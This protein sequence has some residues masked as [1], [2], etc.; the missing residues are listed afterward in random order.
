MKRIYFI[1][2]IIISII[3]LVPVSAD[4]IN[5][6]SNNAILYNI[7]DDIVLYEKNKDQKVSIASMTKLMTALVAVENIDNLNTKVK[8]E[9]S[10]YEKL[11]IQ[12]AS[13]SSL[14]R[15]RYYT[16]EDLLYGLILES[17]ADCANAL[18]RLTAGNEENFVKK[19]NE[20]AKI[21]GMNN[22]KFSNPIGLDNVNNYSTVEDVA[23][24]L[25]KDLRNPTLNK[26]I[27]SLKHTLS[28]GTVIEHTIYGYM[29][30]LNIQAPY[31]QGGKTGYETKSGFALAS[32]AKN[33]DTTLLLVTSLG[34]HKGDHIKDAKT[35]YEY[36]YTNYS[37][38]PII[39]KNEEI[40]K[41]NAKYLSKKRISITADKD[42]KYYLPNN[43][44]K[45]DIS[46]E[47]QGL[48]TLTLK[49]QINQ[50]IGKV[51][52]YYKDKH[53]STYQVVLHEKLYPSKIIIAAL[54]LI[55]VTPFWI[56]NL[57]DKKNGNY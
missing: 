22:T 52:I 18:A 16:Y 49:N 6:N 9:K 27:T 44:K 14:K 53:I 26:I 47:Y 56:K 51:K 13:S 11:L 10:D 24:L 46:L 7:N 39:K 25:K 15:D 23:I 38:Q 19:M 43:Y 36:Y 55:I 35:L 34:K 54:I 8:L 41:L 2:I 4:S 12:D 20:R 30:N 57:I 31:I 1:T 40:I 33:D 17:G 50:R 45:D 3:L 42:I 5:I 29:E 32:I 48:E 28:D 37:Y 21:L